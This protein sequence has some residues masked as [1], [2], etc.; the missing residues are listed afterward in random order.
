MIFVLIAV[1]VCIVSVVVVIDVRCSTDIARWLPLYPNAQVVEEEY[2]F[3]RRASG[4][5]ITVLRTTD[6]TNVVLK[7]YYQQRFAEA[8]KDPN[9]GLAVTNFSVEADPEGNGTLIY[10]YSR[11]GQ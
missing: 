7:W 2:N 4:I 1:V 5:T 11:C 10:L 3:R 9:R 6:P 8:D